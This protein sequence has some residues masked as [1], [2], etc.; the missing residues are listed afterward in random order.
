MR[1]TSGGGEVPVPAYELFS[2]S[3][4]LGRM[5]MGKMLGGLSSRRQTSPL[6]V[7]YRVKNRHAADAIVERDTGRCSAVASALSGHVQP[8]RSPV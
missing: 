8:E 4:I 7:R 6:Q 5:A 2:S 3:E 1:A